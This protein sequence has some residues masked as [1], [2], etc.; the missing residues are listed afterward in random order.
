MTRYLGKSNRGCKGGFTLVELLVVIVVLAI[1]AAI[2]L[3]K[4]V[5]SSLRS[6]ESALKS[7]LKLLRNAVNLFYADTGYYP[8]QLSDLTSTAAPAKGVDSAGAQKDI[9]ATDYHGPYLQ[10]VP[11]DPVSAAAF[12]YNT[13]APNVGEVTSSATGNATDGTAY[14]SW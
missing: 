2:V 8:A 10:E 7:D 4:F 11:D 3:P 13:T 14:S 9:T 1:L 12:T 6:K 5:D